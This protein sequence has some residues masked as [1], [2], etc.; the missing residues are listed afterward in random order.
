[1]NIGIAGLGLIG[2][3]LAKAY[4]AAGHS[5]FGF[6]VNED[7]L[8]F[9][10]ISGV[11]EGI[12]DEKSI[13]QCEAVFIAVNPGDAIDYL[14][15]T[16]PGIAKN[17]LVID[18]CGVKRSVCSRCFPLAEKYGFTFIG[19]HP[20]AG[21]HK[22]GFKNSRADLF[23][24]AYIIIVPPVYDDPALF[25]RIEDILKPVGFGHFTVTTAEK[26]DKMIAFTSQLAHIVSN[27]Y[28]KSP[29]ARGHKGFS[30][31]S[32]KDLTRVAR[33]N[34][35]MWGELCMDNSKFLVRELDCFIKSVTLYRDA[36]AAHDRTALV[37]LLEKGSRL[38]E[39]MDH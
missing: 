38:K 29:A 36:L 7:V 19:G 34:A 2:G 1:M 14:E 24:G 39:E 25:A 15:K 3:S 22:A 6:D 30:A 16:A 9:A 8:S 17:T 12:L 23:H 32:Y 37:K 33:L 35:D 31:G 11:I 21:S 13:G 10:Q 20:M 26:H 4:Q 5:V 27:A 18:C 28:I